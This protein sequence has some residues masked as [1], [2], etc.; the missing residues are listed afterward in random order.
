MPPPSVI[1]SFDPKFFRPCSFPLLRE[2]G[3]GTRV[4]INNGLGSED[5]FA[6]PMT[7]SMTAFDNAGG[8]IGSTPEI[9]TLEPGELLKLDIDAELAHIPDTSGDEALLIV[10]HVVP[11]KW[12]NKQS[13]DVPAAEMMAHVRASDDFV[14]YHQRPKGV[15]TGVAYQTGPLNDPRLSSTRTTVCQAPKVIVTE[16]VDTLF[17][18]MN[19]STRSDYAVTVRMDFWI[20][21]PEGERFA[22]S[23]VDVPPFSFRLVSATEV[24]ERAGMLDDYR[25]RGGTGMLLGLSTNGTVAPISLTRNR[26]T[27]AIACDHTLPPGFYLSTW[28]G[29]ARLRANAR[30]EQEF[31]PDRASQVASPSEVAR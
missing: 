8:K 9:A 7:V 29:E 18:L 10:L 16:P 6:T 24:L 28:G 14:E 12:A 30:L 2:L 26:I 3:Y 21:G 17:A 4:T 23:A 11:V 15:V 5:P 27:G 20:L 31:F 22:R 1:P 19:L 13:V 25:G